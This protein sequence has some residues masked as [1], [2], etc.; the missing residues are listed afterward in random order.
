MRAQRP[1]NYV[2]SRRSPDEAASGCWAYLLAIS[3]RLLLAGVEATFTGA[4]ALV[5]SCSSLRGPLF[6]PSKHIQYSILWEWS[7]GF[8][9][10]SSES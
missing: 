2:Q 7:A 10:E 6:R 3:G 4:L 9:G 1:C 5:I 8:D